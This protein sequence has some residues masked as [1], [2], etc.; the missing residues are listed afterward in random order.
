MERGGIVY[1]LT[2]KRHTVLYVGVTSNLISRMYKYIQNIYPNS[3][4]KKYNIDKL[5]YFEILPSIGEAIMR[6]KQMKAG[7]RIRKEEL[8]GKMNPNWND[9]YPE[10][11]K[12]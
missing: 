9:L 1:I 2:N 7:S 10:I 5:V 12:W 3:F 11:L 6:E 8:I 4:T